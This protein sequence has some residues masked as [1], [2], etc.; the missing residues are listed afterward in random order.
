MKK[1]LELL[2]I[3]VLENYLTEVSDGNR[4]DKI[5]DEW[6]GP[7]YICLMEAIEYGN[8]DPLIGMLDQKAPLPTFFL[9]VIAELI[10]RVTPRKINKGRR[11]AGSR[12]QRRNLYFEMKQ[13]IQA[14]KKESETFA[15]ISS[16][17]ADEN[18]NPSPK[19]YE[20]IFYEFEKHPILSKVD[21]DKVRQIHWTKFV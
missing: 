7:Y 13:Q 20:R 16:R 14:G 9:P 8:V 12:M 15:E 4:P 10:K 1:I 19:T 11:T 5:G 17:Y 2:E 6:V 3:K 21:P 18:G